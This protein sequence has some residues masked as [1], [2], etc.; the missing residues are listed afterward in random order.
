[1][2]TILSHK[3]IDALIKK[4]DLVI[5]PLLEES[6]IGEVSIDFRLG[7]NFLVSSL[8]RNPLI[9]TSLNE[10]FGK[11]QDLKSFFSETRRQLGETITLYPHQTVLASSLEYVKLPKDILLSLN[12]RSSYSRL[13]LTLSTI[14]QPGYC[15]CLSLELTNNNLCP[16]NLTVG[17]RI[18][19]GILH[20][21]S[22]EV[23]YFKVN[24]KYSCAIRPQPAKI[25]SDNDLIILNNLWKKINNK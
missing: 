19:Q 21:I 24:R 18:F 8:G 12:M 23:N 6:Q 20:K 14:A 4:Q 10:E 15:G 7:T 2:S 25:S 16:I 3:E 22:D 13:G 5:R 9:T 1:M 11:S 17:S